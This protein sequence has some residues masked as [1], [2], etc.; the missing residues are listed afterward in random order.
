MGDRTHAAVSRRPPIPL[1]R[2]VACTEGYTHDAKGWA[3]SIPLSSF[4]AG[5][6]EREGRAGRWGFTP[7]MNACPRA[8]PGVPSRVGVACNPV[9]PA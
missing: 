7:A 2:I 6:G 4:T 9:A 3:L 8:E 1:S 5:E